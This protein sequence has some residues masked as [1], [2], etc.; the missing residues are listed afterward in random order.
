MEAMLYEL[1]KYYA[2]LVQINIIIFI[3]N[4]RIL[5]IVSYWAEISRMQLDII[6]VNCSQN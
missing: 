2:Y 1:E 4:I 6:C 3:W 5:V